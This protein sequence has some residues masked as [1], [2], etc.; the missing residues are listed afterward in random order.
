[1]AF[2]SGEGMTGFS[3]KNDCKVLSDHAFAVD[4]VLL[5]MGEIRS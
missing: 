5:A 4:E 2:P 3:V 1:M